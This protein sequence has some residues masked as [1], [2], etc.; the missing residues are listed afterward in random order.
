MHFSRLL[1]TSLMAALVTGHPGHDHSQELNA[2]L[3][4]LANN[5]NDLS[6]CAE[7]M[8]AR[9]LDAANSRR[10]SDLAGQLLKKRGLE[11]RDIASYTD[12]HKSSAKF[13]AET[14]LATV[15]AGNSSCALS[16]EQVEGPYYVAGERIRKDVT[17]TQQGVPLA[18]DIQVV[19]MVTCDP[20]PGAYLEIWHCNA[21]GIYG[22]VVAGGNG[23]NQ[24]KSNLNNT[25]L[26]G[27]QKTDKDGAV[28]F[29][30]IFPGHYTG[31]TTHIHVAVH[32]K[33][34]AQA[35]GTLLDTTAAHV[36]QMYFD[37][38]LITEVEKNAPYT[39]NKQP[40]T[41][42]A[43][44][45]ILTGAAGSSDPV[46]EYVVLGKGVADGLLS[47]LSFGI[48]TTLA[49]E[50]SPAVTGCDMPLYETGGEAN[51][52]AGMGGPGGFPTGFPSGFPTGFP[53]G[54][55]S[56]FPFPPGATPPAQTGVPKN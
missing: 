20:I 1:S 22:G 18:V 13:T 12:S 35:N 47:W 27:A 54:F 4:F 41:T 21:T 32:L 51:P 14:D 16:P 2:R 15:F 50:I 10:R 29:H 11:V 34:V 37:Q 7:K 26:R 39:A 30:T 55:P 24:D 46:M 33:A 53:S 9:G 31:R 23:N 17:E 49:R 40:L 48:N 52:N 19:D 28:Q 43:Q 36:G 45:F 25:M 44:D 3:E 56:G 8:L 38:D 6:H 42:N 5:K